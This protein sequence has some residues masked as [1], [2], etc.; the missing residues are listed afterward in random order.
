LLPVAVLSSVLQQWPASEATR[1]C[2]A[3]DGRSSRAR[4][5]P[6][7][8]GG[9]CEQ[10]D[11]TVLRTRAACGSAPR[12]RP[13]LALQVAYAPSP[14]WCRRLLHLLL[15]RRRLNPRCRIPSLPLRPPRQQPRPLLHLRQPPCVPPPSP[16]AA[17]H[18]SPVHATISTRPARCKE[19]ALWGQH[20]VEWRAGDSRYI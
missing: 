19:S 8:P 6:A 16:A 12:R 3:V 1:L 18:V 7:C 13:W 20:G 9:G 11:S 4:P 10:F 5:S 14:F 15:L 17:Q 2:A